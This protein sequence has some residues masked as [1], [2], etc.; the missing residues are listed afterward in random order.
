MQIIR[1]SLGGNRWHQSFYTIEVCGL[2]EGK[3]GL[4]IPVGKRNEK[5]TFLHVLLISKNCRFFQDWLPQQSSASEKQFLVKPAFYSRMNKLS[6]S[7]C[8]CI[9]SDKYF[10]NLK[11]MGDV[12]GESILPMNHRGREGLFFFCSGGLNNVLWKDKSSIQLFDGG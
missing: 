5:Q 2:T 10:R 1:M 8:K 7:N 11:I 3:M 4:W 12:S 9:L 6:L